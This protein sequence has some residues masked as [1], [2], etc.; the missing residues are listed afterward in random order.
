MAEAEQVYKASI[1]KIKSKKSQGYY[2]YY[3]ANA[4]NDLF[5]IYLHEKR[6]TDAEIVAREA[7]DLR[8]KKAEKSLS[9]LTNAYEHLA[10]IYMIQKRYQDAEPM[11]RAALTMQHQ[12]PEKGPAVLL[13]GYRY[14][15]LIFT[16][17][18]RLAEGEELL[19]RALEV[20]VN[21]GG[22]QD[23]VDQLERESPAAGK[24]EKQTQLS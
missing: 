11:Y 9:R 17:S 16:N 3:L 20:R 1:E 22:R 18:N 2:Y 7:I 21:F 13:N 8:E 6:F 10:H 24:N 4:L 14:L 23:L 5:D 15:G 12:E 19:V